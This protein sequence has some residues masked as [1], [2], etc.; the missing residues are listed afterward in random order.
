VA[1]GAA[2]K[3]LAPN[4]YRLTRFKKRNVGVELQNSNWIRNLQDINT[5]NQMEEFTMLFMALESVCLTDQEDSI[6][7]RWTT[8]GSY[9]VESTYEC[10]FLGAMINFLA[11]DIWRA[12]SQQKC[13]F[14]CLASLAQ[15][16]PHI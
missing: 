10:Q 5:S 1:P 6:S 3:E 4:Q 8:N 9:S 2:P 11:T 13:K 14:F 15:P 12:K 16:S 7:W